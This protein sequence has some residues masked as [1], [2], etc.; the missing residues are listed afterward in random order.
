MLDNLQSTLKKYDIPPP[1]CMSE[2]GDAWIPHLDKLFA[3]LIALGWDK[4]LEQIKYKFSEARIY[5]KNSTP[6]MQQAIAR[7]CLVLNELIREENLL[8]PRRWHE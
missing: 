7:T 8:G 2:A 4:N 3:E 1:R 5:I 6:E